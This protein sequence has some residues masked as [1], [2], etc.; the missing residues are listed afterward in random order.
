MLP[1]SRLANEITDDVMEAL[2]VNRWGNPNGARIVIQQA[3][4]ESLINNTK[5]EG[6]GFR[7]IDIAG[8]KIHVNKGS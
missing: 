7:I 2:E 5:L 4:L 1:V 3:I 6:D 8:D